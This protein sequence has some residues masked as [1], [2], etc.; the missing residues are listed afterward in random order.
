MLTLGWQQRQREAPDA[1]QPDQSKG[2]RSGD[3]WV[4]HDGDCTSALA[5]KIGWAH[6]IFIYHIVTTYMFAINTGNP[7]SNCTMVLETF[8]ALEKLMGRLPKNW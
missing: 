8:L 6:V 5:K 1:K 7:D 3:S 4:D 2:D